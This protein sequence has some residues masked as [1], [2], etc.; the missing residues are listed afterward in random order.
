ML[1]KDFISL[2]EF[3]SLLVDLL[4]SII[5]LLSL[6]VQKSSLLIQ[7]IILFSELLLLIVELVKKIL[8]GFLLLGDSKESLS[9]LI[10]SDL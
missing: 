5:H 2:V 6:S 9:I 8:L 4:V 7:L 3:E 1:V 10:L